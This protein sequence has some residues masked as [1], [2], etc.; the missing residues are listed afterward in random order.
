MV[1]ATGRGS[2]P[3]AFEAVLAP[4]QAALDGCGARGPFA[5]VA[6][7]RPEPDDGQWLALDAFATDA[8]AA[9]A[10]GRHDPD[11][12]FAKLT[13]HWVFQN[14]AGTALLAAGYL[15]A[16][17]YRV[18]GLHGNVLLH[19][20]EWLQHLRLVQ[21]RLWALPD[22]PLAGTS[23]V[24]TVADLQAL[25]A[26]LFAAVQRT[27]EPIVQAFRARR[28]VSVANAWASVVDGLLQ[29][30]LLAGRAEIGLDAAWRLWQTT[31]GTWD[32][33]TRRWPRRLPFAEAGLQDEVVVRAACCLIYTTPDAAGVKPPNCPNCP[34][35]IG[36]AG[37]V[38][39]MVEWLRQLEG[40]APV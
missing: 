20:T 11:G 36:D 15:Y 21:P 2:V 4:M 34:L 10:I 26:L 31:I 23:G 29:G 18:P 6:W 14:A 17:Q 12:A 8:G 39:W 40:E 19:N 3:A 22:D 27:Y 25:T 38:R 9:P 1:T 30:F 33:P 28:Q 16:A 5:S 13:G 37:R 24:T 7:G 35:D 32:V